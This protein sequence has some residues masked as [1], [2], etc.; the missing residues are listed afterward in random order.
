MSRAVLETITRPWVLTRAAADGS[1]DEDTVVV[2]RLGERERVLVAADVVDVGPGDVAPAGAP[3]HR[4]PRELGVVVEAVLARIEFGD[5]AGGGAAHPLHPPLQPAGSIAQRPGGGDEPG[6]G[7]D[8]ADL[9]EH[10]DRERVD[11]VQIRDAHPAFGAAGGGEEFLGGRPQGGDQLED[12]LGGH[13]HVASHG[14]GGLDLGLIQ[15]HF[16]TNKL[17]GLPRTYSS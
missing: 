12:R 13:G 17:R 15:D 2:D 1:A 3:G 5:E 16:I 8:P 6:A 4:E 7:D 11:L 10:A 14:L 9:A